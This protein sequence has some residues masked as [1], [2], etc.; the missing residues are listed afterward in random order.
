MN[1]RELVYEIIAMTAI[2]SFVFVT[3]FWVWMLVNP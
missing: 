1:G 2:G 3:M